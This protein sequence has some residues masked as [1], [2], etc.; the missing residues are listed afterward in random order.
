MG[1]RYYTHGRY[2]KSS[3]L[4]LSRNEKKA[5]N[6]IADLIRMLIYIVTGI[7]K[8]IWQA[9]RYVQKIRINQREL[10]A[11]G[12]DL[13]KIMNLVDTIT[14]R[15]FEVLICELFHQ[16]GY[17]AQ[18]TPPGND[19]GRDVILND[20]I[21][22]EC[23]HY[24]KNNYVGREICQKLLGSMQMFN[25]EKGIIVTTGPYHKN[26][27]EVAA[28]VDN[29]QLMDSYDI[30]RMILDLKSDQISKI[31]MRTLNAS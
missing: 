25:A 11:I 4:S 2:R 10:K 27:Y 26:A 18:L 8:G 17:K 5:F 24:N 12:Y 9:S 20:N 13:D 7:C 23:K 30:Q 14:P 19:Y 29:L 3:I 21:F 1:R 28:K 16:H 15:Q 31:I 22:V 6:L